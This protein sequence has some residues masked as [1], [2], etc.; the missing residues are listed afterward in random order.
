M[1]RGG[2]TVEDAIRY[3]SQSNSGTDRESSQTTR[4]KATASSQQTTGTIASEQLN[5]ISGLVAD[6]RHMEIL[7]ILHNLNSCIENVLSR[8]AK[9]TPTVASRLCTFKIINL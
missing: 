2:Q 6:Q 8:Q 7:S 4:F 9:V 1:L 3:L 5:H